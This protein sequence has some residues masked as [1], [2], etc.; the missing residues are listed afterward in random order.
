MLSL[1]FFQ[2]KWS[3]YPF[4]FLAITIALMLLLAGLYFK[5]EET[6]NDETSLQ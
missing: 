1:L 6:Q 3:L 4:C 5:S 2:Q